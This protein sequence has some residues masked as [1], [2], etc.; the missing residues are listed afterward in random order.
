MWVA[1]V[2]VVLAVLMIV[3]PLMAIR[4]T[5][6]QNR[7]AGLR[8]LA[9]KEGLSVRMRQDPSAHNNGLVA[10]YTYYLPGRKNNQT[11]ETSQRKNVRKAN[12]WLL[13]RRDFPHEL[14]FQ[15]EWD[16]LG[17]DRPVRSLQSF[18]KEH[19]M[20]LDGSFLAVE[21]SGRGFSLYW[22]ERLARKTTEQRIDELA[23][24]LKI[25]AEHEPVVAGRSATVQV[26]P[27]ASA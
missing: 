4:P 11:G 12:R 15:G 25:L 3:G 6:N 10:V 13:T 9:L 17:E 24:W 18:L 16:W 19:V 8:Q 20:E 27:D 14:H 1:L 7:L 23:S 22:T 26:N 2:I 21:S 5:K